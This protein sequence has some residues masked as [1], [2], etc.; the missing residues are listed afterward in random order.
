MHAQIG[1]TLI[2]V[3]YFIL[4]CFS[5][6][7]ATLEQW[8]ETTGTLLWALYQSLLL[9]SFPGLV[10]ADVGLRWSGLEIRHLKG[11]STSA[12]CARTHT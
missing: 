3:N 7:L 6:S 10:I 1:E 2:Y 8:K 5:R 11:S 4:A 12:V 9:F